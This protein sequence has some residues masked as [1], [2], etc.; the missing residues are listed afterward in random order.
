MNTVLI[1]K[2]S[3]SKKER[4]PL[5]GTARHTVT[6]GG[7]SRV[8]RRALLERQ[9][10]EASKE[11]TTRRARTVA[12]RAE[13][14]SL[15]QIF[16]KIHYPYHAALL[17]IL[18]EAGHFTERSSSA[19]ANAEE[20]SER[21]RPFFTGSLVLDY[22]CGPIEWP[23]NVSLKVA[24]FHQLSMLSICSRFGSCIGALMPFLQRSPTSLW[25]EC[26]LDAF[27]QRANIVAE[28]PT[29][30]IVASSPG[31]SPACSS[32]SSSSR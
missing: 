30:P 4:G 26:K 7:A 17:K 5:I 27:R 8:R 12:G 11:A 3:F 20:A 14:E 28:N 13:K 31:A 2:I 21:A 16:A 1:L 32:A 18:R 15:L 25:T 6:L 24:A 10:L 22:I 19:L 9:Q 23:K 29:G